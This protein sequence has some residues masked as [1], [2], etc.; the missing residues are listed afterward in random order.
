MEDIKIFEMIIETDQGKGYIVNYCTDPDDN[1][2][3]MWYG[4]KG[5]PIMKAKTYAE[6]K[7]KFLEAMALAESVRKLIY[8]SKHGKLPAT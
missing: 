3:V 1:Q 2:I 5:G 4:G 6:V 7:L 8:F